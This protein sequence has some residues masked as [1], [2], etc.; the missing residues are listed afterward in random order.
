M[1]R[2][3]VCASGYMDPIHNGHIDYFRRSKELGDFLI[4]IVNNDKQT[5]AK[6]GFVVMP[7][8]DRV[9]LIRELRYVDM[10]VESIDE[11]RDVS[12]TLAMLHPDV[13]TNGGDQFNDLIPERAICEKM[14]IEMVDGLGKKT[15]SSRWIIKNIQNNLPNAK[16]EWL[17]K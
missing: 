5:L 9:K 10:A 7:A 2:R 16:T 3:I 6:K 12:H 8:A 14:G 1:S 11:G 15:E 13:F 17:D 4:V